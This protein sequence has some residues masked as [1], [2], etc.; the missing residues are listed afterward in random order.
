MLRGLVS[1][2]GPHFVLAHRAND[3]VLAYVNGRELARY[4]GRVR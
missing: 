2:P 4:G 1:K 3:D